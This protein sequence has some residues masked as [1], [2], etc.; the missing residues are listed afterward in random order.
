MLSEHPGGTGTDSAVADQHP[1]TAQPI[2]PLPLD[3]QRLHRRLLMHMGRNLMRY[4]GIEWVLKL[5]LKYLRPKPGKPAAVPGENGK[6]RTLG[7]LVAVLLDRID[8]RPDD[9]S[10]NQDLFQSLATERVRKVVADRNTLA[11]TFFEIPGVDSYSK[12]GLEK[13]I[14]RLDA[15]YREALLFNDDLT[16][17][18]FL[19]TEI[20]LARPSPIPELRV[21]NRLLRAYAQQRGLQISIHNRDYSE[22]IELLQLAE[23]EGPKQHEMTPLTWAGQYIRKS[24]PE[25]SPEL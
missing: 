5:I 25:F 9:P 2:L 10:V 1:E 21:L 16:P 15:M 22:I 14:Q 20:L 8:F 4:Q 24:M 23:R 19:Y 6:L 13:G 17:F 11:H 3:L 12:E 18:L 7:V